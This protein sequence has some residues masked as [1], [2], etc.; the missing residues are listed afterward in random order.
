MIDAIRCR[1]LREGAALCLAVAALTEVAFSAG[2]PAATAQETAPAPL[3]LAG[4]EVTPADPGPATLCQ[5]RVRIENRAERAVYALGFELRL[6][7][8]S[9]PVY[10]KHLYYQRLPPGETTEI[11][12]FNFWTT[13][14]GRPR[15]PDGKLT[16]DVILREAAWLEVT[17]ER[18]EGSEEP[19]EVWT[20]AGA[21]PGLPASRSVTLEL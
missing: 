11:R 2:A 4:V 1:R 12:L 7:G 18:E 8:E 9:L 13:E 14:T 15:P 16:V 20:P 17:S 6:A 10:A 3:V 19:V 21:V 5:L